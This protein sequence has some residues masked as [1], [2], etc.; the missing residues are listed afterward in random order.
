MKHFKQLIPFI[1]IFIFIACAD[2]TTSPQTGTI[3]VSVVDG[4]TPVPNQEIT[5]MPD[6]LVKRT[7]KNGN[8]IFEVEEGHYKVKANVPGPGPAGYHYNETVTIKNNETVKIKLK[9]CIPCV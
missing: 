1:I 3:S 5:L 2:E 7:D 8:C 4:N 6:S 9:A